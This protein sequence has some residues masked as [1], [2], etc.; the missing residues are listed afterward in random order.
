[1]GDAMGAPGLGGRMSTIAMRGRRYVG[2][3]APH[4][5]ATTS[6]RGP[7]ISRRVRS[8]LAVAGAIALVAC[9]GGGGGRGAP[10]DVRGRVALGAL[11][12]ATVSM[13]RVGEY[14][15]P[16]ATTT[17]S[18]GATS[19]EIGKFTFPHPAAPSNA[20]FLLVVSGG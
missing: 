6:E 4:L 20:L 10:P 3:T 5:S 14:G 19:A 8:F 1:M 2:A 18:M 13:Y 12:G 9:G 15:D 17:S 16:V 11:G 7:R